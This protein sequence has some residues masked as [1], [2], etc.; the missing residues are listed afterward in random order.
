MTNINPSEFRPQSP[1]ELIGKAGQIATA[2]LAHVTGLKHKTD[3]RLKMLIYGDAGNGKSAIA[4]M[5]AITLASD[6]FDIETINGRDLTIEVVREWIERAPYGS[7]FGGWTIKR[8]EEID[9]TP[10][11]AQELMLTYLDQLFPKR[12][13]IATSNANISNL[14]DRFQSRFQCVKIP[15]PSAKLIAAWLNRKFSVKVTAAKQIAEA[16]AGN[17]R[18]ACLDASNF[19]NF[20]T[21]PEKFVQQKVVCSARSAAAL[22]AWDTMRAKGIASA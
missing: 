9:L 19:I 17:V 1:K 11:A 14:T 21:L 7:M 12:A 6:K 2:I 5:I 4:D 3:S 8:I 13:I 22:K 15:V 16:C 18:R 20:G 10:I